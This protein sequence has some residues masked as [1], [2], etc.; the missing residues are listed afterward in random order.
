MKYDVQSAKGKG[1]VYL[2]ETRK[3]LLERADEHWRDWREMASTNMTIGSFHIKSSD[4]K[5]HRKNHK[6]HLDGNLGKIM[7]KLIFF[8]KNIFGIY[9]GRFSLVENLKFEMFD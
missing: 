2:R 7:K 5:H 8:Q 3:S 4:S 1:K 9:Q 6:N